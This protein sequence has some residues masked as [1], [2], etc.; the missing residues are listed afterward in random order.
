MYWERVTEEIYLFTSERY[1][2]VNSVAIRTAEG[3]IVID[4]LPFPNEAKKI[5]KFL[6]TQGGGRFHSLI[7]THH[8]ADHSFGLFAFPAYLELLAHE[9]CRQKLLALGEKSLAETRRNH[10]VFDQVTLRLPTITFEGERMFVCAGNHTLRLL[11]LPG[12]TP[13][14]IGV[15]L[16]EEQVLVAGDAVMAIPIIV[17]GDWRRE[18]QTLQKVK[19]LAPLTIIQ[20]HGEVILRGEVN[21]VMDRY[22]HYLT[23]MEEKA[24]KL[25]AD[26]KP[27]DLIWDIP[28]EACGLERVPLGL[29]SQQLHTANLFSIYDQLQAEREGKA[30]LE[31]TAAT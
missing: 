8:H 13:D 9:R 25:L 14:N 16:E 28:L 30:G 26:N 31:N 21:T 17:Q 22:I 6:N 12:H 7:L 2:R 27:R 1:A 10:P 20:G 3:I 18:I 23:C 11:A 24:R 19:E 15:Y 4:A 5:A 29:G